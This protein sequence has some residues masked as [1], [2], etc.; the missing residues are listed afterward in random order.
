MNALIVALAT[1]LLSGCL[2]VQEAFYR[3]PGDTQ[4]L[5]CDRMHAPQLD[6]W[7]GLASLSEGSRYANCKTRLEAAGYVR[8]E[9]DPAA[10]PADE[11]VANVVKYRGPE[12]QEVWCGFDSSVFG[13]VA[14]ARAS[15][16]REAEKQ[17]WVRIE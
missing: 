7:S 2:S 5:K 13:L 10:I 9:K 11:H 3:K 6:I 12:G 16:I 14:A 17:G 15:C 8:V 4:T 1:L